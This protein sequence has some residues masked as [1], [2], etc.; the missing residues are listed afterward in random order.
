MP[1]SLFIHSPVHEHLGCF[2]FGVIVNE[3]SMS[4]CVQVSL[5]ADSFISLGVELLGCRVGNLLAL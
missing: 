4:L 1:H 5:W 3:A 2:Q